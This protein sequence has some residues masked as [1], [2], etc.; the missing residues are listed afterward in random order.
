MVLPQRT[1]PWLLFFITFEAHCKG[2]DFVNGVSTQSR[3][4]LTHLKSMW[5]W[6]PHQEN[7][8]WAVGAKAWR[9]TFWH[10]LSQAYLH[11]R[12]P[13]SLP[14]FYLSCPLRLKCFTPDIVME[15]SLTSSALCSSVGKC[16]C[17]W[18][19]EAGKHWT[20]CSVYVISLSTQSPSRWQ[21]SSLTA[22]WPN[23]LRL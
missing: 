22:G 16:A 18:K 14:S 7:L 12:K 19:N 1:S 15:Q 11:L 10:L 8:C 9:N 4:V 21:V 17:R 23:T 5:S 3:P 20:R 2:Q 13:L 6:E